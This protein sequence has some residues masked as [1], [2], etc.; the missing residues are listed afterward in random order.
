MRSLRI[1][2]SLV[3][4]QFRQRLLAFDRSQCIHRL[5][6]RCVIP[7]P[8]SRQSGSWSQCI[9]RYSQTETPLFPD[10][11]ISRAT[12]DCQCTF[13]PTNSHV[14]EAAAVAQL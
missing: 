10:V 12:S 6:C 9:L 4:C 13:T 7:A 5:E 14:L 11:Q 1:L 2:V 3:V 8:S